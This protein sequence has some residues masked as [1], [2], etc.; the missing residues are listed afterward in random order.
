MDLTFTLVLGL[1]VA[2]LV[3]FFVSGGGKK[4]A[5]GG[6]EKK[7]SGSPASGARAPGQKRRPPKDD[8]AA[9]GAAA[10]A[11]S[12]GS[13]CSTKAGVD[14]V[15]S[16]IKTKSN[17]ESIPAIGDGNAKILKRNKIKTTNQLFGHFL[18]CG[19]DGDAFISSLEEMGLSFKPVPNMKDPKGELKLA[20]TEKWDLMAEK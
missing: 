19:A 10:T 14:F 16:P 4:K 13:M 9:G 5:A 15:Q 18:T 11:S 20:F 7:G 1:V 17:L 6:D 2:V 8:V 12:T 3:F